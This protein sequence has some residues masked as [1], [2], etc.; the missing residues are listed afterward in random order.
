MEK[1]PFT[2]SLLDDDPS[3]LKAMA[4]LFRSVGWPV[5]AFEDPLAF[6]DHAT[7]QHPPVAVIDMSMPVMTGHEVQALLQKFSPATEVIFLTSRDDSSTRERALA[8]GAFAFLLKPAD[9]DE[10]LSV[11]K[12]AA[13]RKR[14]GPNTPPTAI[15]DLSRAISE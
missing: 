3:I 12:S 15:P 9:E 7:A 1:P 2:V 13:M 11:V 8:A 5:A 14:S 6:L 10:L 4:R